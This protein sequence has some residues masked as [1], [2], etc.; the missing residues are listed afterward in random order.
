MLQKR[1]V[2]VLSETPKN[3]AET[4]AMEHLKT[5]VEVTF[6][7]PNEELAT[8]TGFPSENLD[9]I[10]GDCFVGKGMDNYKFHYNNL[11]L[12]AFPCCYQGEAVIEKMDIFPRS[13]ETKII[14]FEIELVYK[15]DG[16]IDKTFHLEGNSNY[17]EEGKLINW[18]VTGGDIKELK[19]FAVSV[20]E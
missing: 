8:E 2:N 19:E 4:K 15:K 18:R 6:I 7:C 5:V 16:I 14:Q 11:A 12:S 9:K 13:K 3:T 10:L 17:N 20:F 1:K